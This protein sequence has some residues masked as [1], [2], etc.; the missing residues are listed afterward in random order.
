MSTLESRCLESFPDWL[1]TLAGDAGAL[2][3]LLDSTENEVLVQAAARGLTYLS[4]SLDL[5]PDGLEE[6]GY[7]DD[8]FVLRVA[9]A[10]VPEPERAEDESGTISRLAAD[11]ELI[12][13]FLAEEYVRLEAF[14][15]NLGSAS[16]RGRS[17]AEASSDPEARAALASD[18][19]A[20]AAG[21]QCP[22]FSRDVKNLVKLHSFL[23]HKLP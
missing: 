8:A 18:V 12:R 21:Y 10:R 17:V 5:I 2:A 13:E 1:R 7:V 4:K 19:R 6:L 11:V 16:A 9:A 15:E 3:T 14:V 23:K 22:S 20:W